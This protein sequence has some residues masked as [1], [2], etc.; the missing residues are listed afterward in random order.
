[1]R[2]LQ[3]IARLVLAV[4]FVG[5]GGLTTASLAR[6]L[7]PPAPVPPRLVNDYAGILQQEAFGLER[8]L[9][10][11]NDSTSNQ[12]T[13]VTLNDLGNYSASQMAYEI[14]ERWGV[15]NAKYDNGVVILIK[16][17]NDYGAGE[18]FIA[19]GYGLEAVLPDAVCKRI[20]DDEMIP[21]FRQGEYAEG[22][23]AAL[24]VI[25]P[26]SAGE[27]SVKEYMP[28]EDVVIALALIFAIMAA[29]L[30][31]FAVAVVAAK[32]KNKNNKGGGSGGDDVNRGLR[33]AVL[34]TLLS[35]MGGSSGRSHSGGGFGGGGFGGFGGGSFGG[36]GAGGRF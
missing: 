30:V 23:L 3:K 13:I 6:N 12:I 4:C 16:P 29:G 18:V 5:A 32:N 14:G 19:P 26:L 24:Q 1:M 20:V 10:A 21:Y 31:V 22:V 28:Q 17:R 15:G 33:T 25:M 7:V 35:G 36:G 8:V 27:I 9:R 11:F 2:G 34:A